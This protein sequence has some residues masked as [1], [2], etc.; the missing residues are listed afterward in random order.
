MANAGPGTNGSQFFITH[1][2]TAWLDGK[3]SVFGKVISDSDQEVVN[4]IT[5]SDKIKS[6]SIEGDV[7]NLLSGVDEVSMWNEVLDERFPN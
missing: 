1:I 4:S 6:I 3:H 7:D 5:Q 2:E